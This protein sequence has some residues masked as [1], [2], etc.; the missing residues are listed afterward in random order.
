MEPGRSFFSWVSRR[1]LRLGS[2]FSSEARNSLRQLALS[3][4]EGAVLTAAAALALWWKLEAGL[5][6]PA[7]V[8]LAA[9]FGV[10]T[11][12]VALLV[13][14][15]LHKVPFGGFMKA[16]GAGVALRAAVLAALMA[17]GYGTPWKTQGALLASYTLG[18]LFLL[19]L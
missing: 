19:L 14:A 10:S 8:G 9:A 18:V 16:F 15:R 5:F 6:R 1:D 11:L 2:I 13:F 7:L 17:A 3:A 12:S 4:I